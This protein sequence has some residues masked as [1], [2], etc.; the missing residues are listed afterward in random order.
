MRAK[1]AKSVLLWSLLAC[2]ISAPAFGAATPLMPV[3]D[4]RPGMKGIGKS[5]F[6]G[7]T[8]EEFDVEILDVMK[9][10]RPGGDAIMARVT[11]GPLPLE[12]SGVLAGMSGSPIYI[13]GKLIG[14]LA[15]IP[16]IF[17]KDT[18]VGITPIHQMLRDAERAHP[19]PESSQGSASSAL[20]TSSGNAGIAS[21]HFSPIQTP[22]V[23]SGV[24]RQVLEF[25]RT[26]LTSW[27]MMP[28]QGGS[29]SQ[30]DVDG[31][32]TDLQPGSAVGVQLLRG[33]MNLSGI[34]TVTYRDEEK[35]IAFGHPM[36]FAGDVK[37]PMTAA[38]VHLAVSN[39]INSFK[40]ASSTKIVGSITQDRLTGISGQIGQ[41]P[42][43]LPL[44]VNIHSDSSSVAEHNY[45]FEVAEH[46][47]FSSLFMK[48]AS[49]NALLSTEKMLGDLTI[50]TRINIE[51]KDAPPLAVENHFSGS[52]G[53]VPAVI[54]A[55]APLD[56]LI[57]NRI[58][59][60]SFERV[61][62]DMDIKNAISSAEIVSVR[63]RDH[64]VHP[65]EDV[66]TTITLRPYGR[67]EL[68]VTGN[69][70]I[71]EDVPQGGLQ[72]FACD[73]NVTSGFDVL[74]A[75]A[76]YQPKNIKQL[77][78]RLQ[79]KS[80]NNTII[81]SLFHMKPGAVV[82]GQELPSPPV[83]MMSL[84][85]SSRRSSGKNSL[86]RGSIIARQSIPTLY[87]INGCTILE[88]VV[89]GR[90]TGAG[91]ALEAVNDAESMKKGE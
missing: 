23:V 17:P 62:L 69:L 34:G 45:H 33:D 49:L 26:Q 91:Q 83:S 16:T 85:S 22:L 54:G 76:K 75:Q 44:D 53:P 65:G 84:M 72:L 74:R 90:L 30:A 47:F 82:Q 68:T 4:I 5:V 31:L 48:V 64:I 25:M 14:A 28:V 11:G 10:Q 43:M 37:L 88:L 73:A 21:S 32:D 86:T 29:M 66:E 20:P 87:N 38:Y 3:D 67:E 70:N 78:E 46:R 63:V 77:K 52:F 40:M 27:N 39:Y 19:L 57:N 60:V 7:T 71:P 55:F 18:I 58:E 51:F 36:F 50:Y 8:I 9:D 13:D 42:R 15:F 81:L 41:L 2:V 56:M 12:E 79:E 1:F 80:S 6:S 59:P 35:I 24:D 89:D 61:S